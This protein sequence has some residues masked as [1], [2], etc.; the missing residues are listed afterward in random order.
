VCSWRVPAATEIHNASHK[1]SFPLNLFARALVQRFCIGLVCQK[2][3]ALLDLDL[4]VLN[5]SFAP[6][7]RMPCIAEVRAQEYYTSR[8]SHMFIV[9]NVTVKW[10]FITKRNGNI[11]WNVPI[12]QRHHN[13]AETAT[14]PTCHTTQKLNLK[15]H[16]TRV[17][18]K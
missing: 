17:N 16:T 18:P 5:S 13:G 15:Y 7:R 9:P 12:A 11:H 2:K 6:V 14:V 4:D 8:S 1:R 10:L 3:L